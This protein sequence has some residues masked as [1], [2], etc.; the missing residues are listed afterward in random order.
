MWRLPRALDGEPV[1][2]AVAKIAV[3]IWP[4]GRGQNF[5]D[6]RSEVG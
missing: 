1:G 5:V 6:D 2:Q 3:V 4:D